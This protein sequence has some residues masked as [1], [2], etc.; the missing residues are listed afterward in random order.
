[1]NISL[2]YGG[3]TKYLLT[4]SLFIRL[5]AEMNISSTLLKKM[6]ED[7][8]YSSSDYQTVDEDMSDLGKEVNLFRNMFLLGFGIGVI[9]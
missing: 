7:S 1:M 2:G 3:E 8:Y 9:L 6:N 5:N 4:Q